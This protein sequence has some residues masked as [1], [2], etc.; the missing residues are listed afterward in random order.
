MLDDGELVA[1]AGVFPSADQ[2]REL[3][4]SIE[5]HLQG[6]NSYSTDRLGEAL[7][8]A[9]EIAKCASGVL[10]IRLEA[11]QPLL[12]IWLR[13]EQI[14]EI[15][16]A[17]DPTAELA[18]LDRPK[19][20]TPRRSFATWRE[21]VRGR[22]RPWLQH[23]IDAVELFRT[24]VGYAMQRH[25]LKKLNLAL[26]EANSLLNALATTDPLTGLPNRRLF[27]ERLDEEWQRVLRQ[28]GAFGI[29]AI[30]VDHF[31]NFNDSFGHPAG[32]ECLK[33]VA[34]AIDAS[35]RTIDI[36]ARIGGEEF[37]ILLPEID[38]SGAVA[39]AERVREAIQCLALDH[40]H[41]EGG[42]VTVSLGVA[43][44]SPSEL[45]NPSELM[46]SADRALYQAKTGGRNRVSVSP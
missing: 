4:S 32:D 14:E 42:V 39:A 3:S 2:L 24:R 28:G 17:G 41:N 20:L 38:A 26:A 11:W 1:G 10:A 46:A 19:P 6:R 35:C 8:G 18:S 29:V 33:Q 30:D 40:P 37:A 43:V 44:G 34:N 22:S 27:D 25:R 31:K 9:P 5:E 12:A 36:G 23:E 21:I 15:E 16:W 13:P 7:A 45:A